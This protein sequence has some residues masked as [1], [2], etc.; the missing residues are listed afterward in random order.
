MTALL[1]EDPAILA[2]WGTRVECDSAVARLEREGTLTPRNTGEA[3]QRLDLLSSSWQEIQAQDTLRE[4]AR[5]LLRTHDLRAADAL[6]L[7]AAIV[8]SEGRPASLVFVCLD[9]RLGLAAEREGF[10]VVGA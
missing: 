7:S 8:A 5:R 3:L 1:R 9:G 10:P 2:W 6:Q 4:H